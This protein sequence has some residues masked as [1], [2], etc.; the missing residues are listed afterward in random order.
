MDEDPNG[1]MADTLLTGTT[2]VEKESRSIGDAPVGTILAWAKSLSGV[3]NLA[4][5]WVECDGSV[6]VDAQSSLNGVTLPDLNGG[7]FLEGQTTS[8]ATGGTATNVHTLNTSGSAT[9]RTS[10]I[11]IGTQGGAANLIE[12]S[13]T[14]GGGLSFQR[15]TATTNSTEN[16]PPFYTVV[17]IMRVR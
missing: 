10:D 14:T 9:N 12:G 16:R 11:T 4:E 8:G 6:L 1:I 13:S 15:H 17:W 3:P 5:G 2:L 7:E